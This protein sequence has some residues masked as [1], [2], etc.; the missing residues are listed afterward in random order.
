[1]DKD[2]I[3]KILFLNPWIEQ[4]DLF[5]KKALEYLPSNTLLGDGT[6]SPLFLF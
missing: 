2:L 1:M 6:G 3:S 5:P 4:K